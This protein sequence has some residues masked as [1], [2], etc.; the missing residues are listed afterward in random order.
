MTGRTHDLAA[1]TAL[2]FIVATQPIPQISLPTAFVALGANM[3]GGLSPDM[4]QSTSKFWHS[5]PTGSIVGKF[6]SPLLG[7]HRFISHSI[8]G[9]ALFGILSNY[10]LNLTRSFLL[11]DTNIVWLSF[12]IGFVSHLLA[13]SLTREGV[14]WLFPIPIR[15]GF[16]PYKNLRFKT[17]GLIEKAI[18]FPIL[19]LINGYILY[20][21][22]P[23]FLAL[24]HIVK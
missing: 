1:F 18:V 17:G 5:F 12:M 7:G 24:L 13:D 15:F 16:P 11:V 4:D 21:Y 9:I 23:R 2:T 14:P 19:L 10:L 3:L 8:V 6:I 20:N 22:Y